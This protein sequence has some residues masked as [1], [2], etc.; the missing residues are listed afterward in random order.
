MSQEPTHD[1]DD[2]DKLL[3]YKK[4]LQLPIAILLKN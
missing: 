3:C 4:T 1:L 2:I